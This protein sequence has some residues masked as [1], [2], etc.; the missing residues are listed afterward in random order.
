MAK[1]TPLSEKLGRNVFFGTS[2]DLPRIIEVDLAR[3]RENPDQPRKE[4]DQDAL[5][6]LADSIARHGL[7]QPI[8]VAPDPNDQDYFIVVAGGRRFRA[9]KLLNRET[10]PAIITQGNLDEIALI[11]NIQRQDLNPLEEAEALA[12]MIDRHGYTQGE[13]GKVIGKRQNTVSETLSLNTLPQLIKDEYRTS[14]IS[15]KTSRISKS[16]LIE[17]ARIDNETEQLALW[18]QVK[19][20]NG[21]VRA[22]R[23]S[24]KKP[25]TGARGESSPAKQLLTAGK[26]FARKLEQMDPQDLVDDEAQYAE[27][28][29]LRNK[30]DELMDDLQM[31][32]QKDPGGSL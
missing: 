11:E 5:Q 30:I 26:S 1:T 9:F 31:S 18:E 2:P 6:E 28:I 13:L 12:K 32:L 19:R 21:T 24:R 17:I 29:E 14:D 3:L 7:I 22:A 8:A 4:F 20:G 25:G 23:Q 27:L 15:L 16:V 10:I